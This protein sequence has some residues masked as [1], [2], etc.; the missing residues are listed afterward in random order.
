MLRK[1]GGTGNAQKESEVLAMLKKK[2]RYWQCSERQGVLAMLRETGGVLAMLRKTE[3][4]QAMLIN[5]GVKQRRSKDTTCS[6]Y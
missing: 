2:V 6:A 4:V 1:K 5:K 3:G